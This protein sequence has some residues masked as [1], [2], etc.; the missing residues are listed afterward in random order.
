MIQEKV[1]LISFQIE[2]EFVMNYVYRNLKI[3]IC[4][5]C[6]P[7]LM[8]GSDNFP[9]RG[10]SISSIVTQSGRTVTDASRILIWG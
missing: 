4:M 10:K 2:D 9:K 5:M 6:L 3:H 8:L 7:S 1:Y